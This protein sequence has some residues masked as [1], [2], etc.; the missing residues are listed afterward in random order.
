M[1]VANIVSMLGTVVAAVALTVL[2]YEQT[3]SPA[4][5]ASVMALSFLPYLLGGVLL[6][7][8][9]DR[10][11]ARRALVVCDLLS[12]VLVAA[13]VIPG[14]PVAA[15]LG[16]LFANGLLAPVYQGVR[17]AVLP[18]VLPPGPGYILGRSMMRMVAQSAQI[19]GYGAGGLLLTVLVPARRAGLRRGLVRRLG[20]AAAGRPGP[21]ARAGA[22]GPGPGRWPAIRCAGSAACWPTGRSGASCCSAGSCPRARSPP[23]PS[24]RRTPATSASRPG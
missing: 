4:L 17:A 15:L 14:M 22:A 12:A 2:V 9:A 18:D 24:P 3:R 21:A 20:R 1:F 8:A 10:L 23:R 6:G 11:P 19:V 13:M 5:A 7:A 16:L